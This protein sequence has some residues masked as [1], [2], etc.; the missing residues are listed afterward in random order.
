M[1]AKKKK[2]KKKLV[3]GD[4]LVENQIPNQVG[5]ATIEFQGATTGQKVADVG[6]GTVDMAAKGFGVAGVPGAIVGGALGLGTKLLGLGKQNKAESLMKKQVAAANAKNYLENAGRMAK[7]GKLRSKLKVLHGG[8]L[9]PISPDAVQVRANN[10]GA[11][12]SVELEQAFVDNNEI[13]DNKDRVFSDDLKLPT[14]KSI[15][16]QAKILEKMKGSDRFSDSNDRIEG[17][18]NDLFNY[19]QS[20][21]DSKFTNKRK[22]DPLLTEIGMER[23]TKGD[24]T[25]LPQ[26]GWPERDAGGQWIDDAG[27]LKTKPIYMK[28]KK[29]KGG[30]LKR[31]LR[32]GDE[33]LLNENA[34]QP[35]TGIQPGEA[36]LED[37]F[38]GVT[39]KK[40]GFQLPENFGQKLGTGLATFG[41]NVLNQ[42]LQSRLKG[43]ASPT[44]E[45]TTR[46]DRIDPRAQLA[47]ARNATGQ[48]QQSIKSNTAGAGNFASATGSLLSKRLGAEN[49][50]YGQTNQINTQIGNQEAMLN[51]ATKA[52]NN[53]RINDYNQNTLDFKNKK[54]QLTSE[55]V[56]N[57]SG[58]FLQQGRERN[59][60][61]RDKLA[62]EILGKG[63]GDSG[64]MQR[65]LD[66]IIEEYMKRKG[67]SSKPGERFGGKLSKKKKK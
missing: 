36:V 29:N 57:A 17:K 26:W 35:T 50:I 16:Q 14:G 2:G 11:T 1:P 34:G 49:Q 19:Q 20:V 13:I 45:N 56:A 7:G 58:K 22:V 6:M 60:I 67:I 28:D 65:N 18:L 42:I 40:K 61:D 12:D 53:M 64:V 54:L 33:D 63:Y 52:R 48:A 44:L 24:T 25:M 10:P 15:A 55:N 62:L 4:Y 43:P 39:G 66:V 38:A 3:Y 59:E 46:L 27:N 31:K 21:N 9:D 47:A 41:P 8:E 32:W 5:P 23:L 30:K 37:G 51:Q